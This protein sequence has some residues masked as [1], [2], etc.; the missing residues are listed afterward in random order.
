LPR[1]PAIQKLNPQTIRKWRKRCDSSLYTFQKFGWR[2]EDITP[3]VHLPL[4]LE[5]EKVP[6][7]Y[8]VCAWR[9]MFK[10]SCVRAAFTWIALKNPNWAVLLIMNR[11]ENAQK[12]LKFIDGK[13]RWGPTSGLLQ[14]MYADRL[15]EFFEK[16]TQENLY[17]TRTDPN[18][19]PFLSIAG[20]DSKLESGH[21]NHLVCEDLE[22]ADEDKAK[23]PG[24]EGR[25]F[26]F[27]RTD[28]LLQKPA[29]NPI[30]LVGT[31]HG[32]DPLV[33]RV[34]DLVENA[35]KGDMPN[36]PLNWRMFWKE[37]LDSDGN[38][39]WEERFPLS[40]YK[41]LQSAAALSQDAKRKWDQQYMLRRKSVGAGFFD[42]LV[43]Y[44]SLDLRPEKVKGGKPLFL[45][46]PKRKSI[47][48]AYCW[49]YLHMDFQHKNPADRIHQAESLW[50]IIPVYVAPDMHAFVVDPW[51][52]D[53][54]P[55]PGHD[56]SDRS[57]GLDE[58]DPED[59]REEHLRQPSVPADPLA[60]EAEAPR[61]AI[62]HHA[63]GR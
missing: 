23:V 61:E 6:L 18:A 55:A 1:A 42:M 22:G 13:F 60:T 33:W 36:N 40:Y 11:Y 4:L 48:L 7:R 17:L 54:R 45:D 16:S 19:Q 2:D 51:I 47:D 62:E 3:E 38:S 32:D 59:G 39:R 15:E 26:L 37:A 53:A 29:E 58:N 10:S 30:W 31:P 41:T 49:S 25:R 57:P 21:W 28:P 12:F 50:A 35:E 56:R 63:V 27:N 20:M 43:T 46:S 52:E 14:E 8:L 44:P 5:L 9:G 24:K 34:R